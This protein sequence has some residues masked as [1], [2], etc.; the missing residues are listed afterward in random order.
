MREHYDTDRLNV[1]LDSPP[2]WTRLAAEALWRCAHELPDVSPELRPLM[3]Q[4]VDRLCAVLNRERERR[5]RR[6]A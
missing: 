2:P 4:H 1:K 6:A 5:H 3:S